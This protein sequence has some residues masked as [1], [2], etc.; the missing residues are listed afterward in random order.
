MYTN[1][2]MQTYGKYMEWYI[3]TNVNVQ[4][5]KRSKNGQV[6]WVNLYTSLSETK[7]TINFTIQ[8]SHHDISPS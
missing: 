2:C 1:K 6:K 4:V 8:S 5:Y 3:H 7:S